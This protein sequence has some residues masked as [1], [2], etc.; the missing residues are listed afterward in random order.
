VHAV[1]RRYVRGAHAHGRRLP[2]MVAEGTHLL[3]EVRRVEPREVRVTS[4]FRGDQP[5]GAEGAEQVDARSE[6]PWCQGMARPEVVLTE[7]LAPDEDG[8]L[9]RISQGTAPRRLLPAP[10]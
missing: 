7:G 1:E 10:P 8:L 5:L 6:A 3:D 4:R 9:V 2:G